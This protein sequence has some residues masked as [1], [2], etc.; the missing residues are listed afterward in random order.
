MLRSRQRFPHEPRRSV[1]EPFDSK[2]NF[3]IEG[4]LLAHE[5]DSFSLSSSTY[6]S[7]RFRR[8]SHNWR[9]SVSQSSMT[10]N[11]SGWISYV[12]TRPR[13]FDLTSR[14]RSSSER[15]CTN[16]G[17]CM[18]NGGASS[19]TVAGPTESRSRTCRRVELDRA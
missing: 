9:R 8:D 7:N 18:W 11:R 17:S 13:F 14:L 3:R 2:I 10:L 6:W 1:D 19:L 12:R 4:E 15:C 5:S 16:D